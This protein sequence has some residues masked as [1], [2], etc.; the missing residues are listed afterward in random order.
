[1]GK[2]SDGQIS[3]GQISWWANIHWANVDWAN[4]RWANIQW[5][6]VQLA[7]VLMGK[8]PISKC[9][10]GKCPIGKCPD[11]KK[12]NGQ[13]SYNQI[14]ATFFCRISIFSTPVFFWGEAK[15][16]LAKDLR[17]EGSGQVCKILKKF[18]KGALPWESKEFSNLTWTLRYQIL[19]PLGVCTL[20]ISPTMQ[21]SY[22]QVLD[23]KC[24]TI[25]SWKVILQPNR[26]Q[27]WN[28]RPKKP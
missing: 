17:F 12:F 28:Q 27:K 15:A 2:C 1:M 3:N 6:N 4:V 10:M 11:G 21:I 16:K 8:C 5:A 25:R 13:M 19:G 24:T 14:K 9:P 26:S 18:W 20:H 7:N 22:I 23:P